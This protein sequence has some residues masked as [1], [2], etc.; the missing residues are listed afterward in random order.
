MTVSNRK[1][2]KHRNLAEISFQINFK[3]IFYFPV[4]V[5]GLCAF[6]ISAVTLHSFS[7]TTP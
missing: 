7:M 3:T 1:V 5:Y 6:E 2:K 4:L